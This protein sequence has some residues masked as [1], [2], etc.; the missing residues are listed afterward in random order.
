MNCNVKCK[1]ISFWKKTRKNLQDL[2]LGKE[3][4]DLTPKAQSIKGQ[5]DKLDFIKIKNIHSVKDFVRRM[6]R[7]ACRLGKK[8]LQTAYLTK[9]LVSRLYNEF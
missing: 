5:T 6:E 8:Y 2:Q 1:A 3:F 7:Q 4:R 9:G